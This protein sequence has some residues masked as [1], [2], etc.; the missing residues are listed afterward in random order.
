MTFETKRSAEGERRRP[1]EAV[2][3]LGAIYID[4]RTGKGWKTS[5]NGAKHNAAADVVLKKSVRDT[6]LYFTNAK[7]LC[8]LD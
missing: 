5:P 4:G 3:R 7:D 1:A 8:S 2:F 6:V